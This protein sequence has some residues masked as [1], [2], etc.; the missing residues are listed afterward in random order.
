MK[1]IFKL[2]NAVLEVLASRKRF[3]LLYTLKDEPLSYAELKVKFERMTGMRIGSSEVYKHLNTLLK[4]K[5]IHKDGTR[6]TITK[7]GMK[8]IKYVKEIAETKPERPKIILRFN[9]M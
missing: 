8:A 1:E 7:R 2:V 5:F 9:L 4:H 3:W 6:Y